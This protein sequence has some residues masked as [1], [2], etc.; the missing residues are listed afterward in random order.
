MSTSPAL[1]LRSV[2][3]SFHDRPTSNLPALQKIDLAIESGEVF[4]FIGP[5]G[6]GK[7]TLLRLMCGLET[8]SHGHVHLGEDL[9]PTDI[10]F[11]FQQFA[12]LPWLTVSENIALGLRARHVAAPLIERR[13]AKELATF[14]L[15]KFAHSYPR[16]LSGGMQQRVGIARALATDPKIILMDEPFSEL[17]SFTAQELRRE[18]LDIWSSRQLTIVLVT[19]IIEEAI[20]LANRIAVLSPRPGHIRKIITNT[21]PRPRIERSADFYALEDQLYELVKGEQI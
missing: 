8:V 20:L 21:L 5:S 19:H 16:E 17:D 15:K 1:T 6:C 10:S 9:A 13:V 7:S 11:V 2:S 18:L 14:G 4:V 3:K 12:L